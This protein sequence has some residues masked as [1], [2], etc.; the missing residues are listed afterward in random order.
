LGGVI[1]PDAG[2]LRAG[3]VRQRQPSG[4]QDWRWRRTEEA[5]SAPPGMGSG[6]SIR[7]VSLLDLAFATS[8]ERVAGIGGGQRR[9]GSSA[10]LWDR[11]LRGNLMARAGVVDALLRR[12]FPAQVHLSAR[13]GADRT[14][15]GRVALAAVVLLAHRLAAAADAGG[16]WAG[17]AGWRRRPALPDDFRRA[18]AVRAASRRAG[19]RAAAGGGGAVGGAGGAAGFTG[20]GRA[21]RVGAAF[22]RR[23]WPRPR[24][25]SHVAL[26]SYYAV[27]NGGILAIAWF[28]SW[29]AAQRHRLRLSPSASRRSGACCATRPTSMRRRSLSWSCS[30]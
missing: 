14:A 8:V 22:W 13:A 2:Q 12:C 6:R 15:P 17:A 18:A 4:E 20:A 29:R 5:G 19:L 28:K 7:G 25:G 3:H 10:P 27:L 21:R 26:F 11:L 23:S 16:L 30:S 24:A 9:C 1:V